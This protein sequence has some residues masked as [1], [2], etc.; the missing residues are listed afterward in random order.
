M[1]IDLYDNLMYFNGNYSA[2]LSSN[3]EVPIT[4]EGSFNITL[5]NLRSFYHI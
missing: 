3:T 2:E 5:G 4:A 1:E